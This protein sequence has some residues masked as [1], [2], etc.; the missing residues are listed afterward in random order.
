MSYRRTRS[1]Q[2]NLTH[3]VKRSA[4]PLSL[5]AATKTPAAHSPAYRSSSTFKPPNLLCSA[6]AK[7]GAKNCPKK[8]TPVHNPVPRPRTLI[9]NNCS[10]QVSIVGN[11][12]PNPQTQAITTD[13]AIPVSEPERPAPRYPVLASANPIRTRM[14]PDAPLIRRNKTV[15][16]A[17]AILAVAPI[18]PIWPGVTSV[19]RPRISPSFTMI[20]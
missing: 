2:C 15:P 17:T 8:K 18:A 11:K 16:T 5:V 6:V 13:I 4:A 10:N 9:G 1:Y 14:G 20:V 3:L 19:L 12:I 7:I